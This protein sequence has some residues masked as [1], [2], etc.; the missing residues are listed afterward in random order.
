MRADDPSGKRSSEQK[1]A[2]GV[3]YLLERHVGAQLAD[4]ILDLVVNHRLVVLR[5]VAL[6]RRVRVGGVQT[7][8]YLD[9]I[10][11]DVDAARRATRHS[12]HDVGLKRGLHHAWHGH[13]GH[14]QVEAGTRDGVFLQK[15]AAAVV[16]AQMSL[17]HRVQSIAQY[18]HDRHGEDEGQQSGELGWHIELR[19]CR[20]VGLS[21]LVKSFF[22]K[23]VLGAA[24][25]ARSLFPRGRQ[26]RCASSALSFLKEDSTRRCGSSALFFLGEDS[27]RRC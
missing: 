21:A 8:D 17:G 16:D 2:G 3:R 1:R 12:L 7:V 22:W 25:A 11:D 9:P 5:S 15:L 27:I 18:H 23:T 19:A 24:E 6:E 4:N 10:E 13:E 20:R 26:R 14:H